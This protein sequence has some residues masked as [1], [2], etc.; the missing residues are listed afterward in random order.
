MDEELKK[1]EE[2]YLTGQIDKSLPIFEKLAQDGNGRAMYF[3]G[4]IY[5]NGYGTTKQD[6]KKATFWRKEGRK[7]EIYSPHSTVHTR[8]TQKS[9]PITMQKCHKDILMKALEGDVFAQNEVSDQF[10]YGF[11]VEKMSNT[12]STGSNKRQNEDFG[13][14]YS[15]SEKCTCPEKW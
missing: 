7:K 12:D 14:R 13:D 11:G 6:F 4:E 8:Q 15:N 9:K 3:L 5:G 10:L 1:A 2:L